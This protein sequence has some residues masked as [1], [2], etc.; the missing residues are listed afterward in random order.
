MVGAAP[1]DAGSAYEG[2]NLSQCRQPA[3][4]YAGQSQIASMRLG[5]CGPTSMWIEPLVQ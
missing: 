3:R 2:G 4:H 1:D 5:G